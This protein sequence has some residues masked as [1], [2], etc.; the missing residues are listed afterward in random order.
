MSTPQTTIHICAG[1]RLNNNYDHTIAFESREAQLAYFRSKVVRTYEGYAYLR[2]RWSIKVAANMPDARTWSYLFFMNQS[3]SHPNQR[4]VYYFITDVEY[5]NDHT[6]ELFLELDVMQSYLMGYDYHLQ[7]CFVER[8]HAVT[9]TFGENTNDEGLDTGELV[10][11]DVHS[12]LDLNHMAILMM[13][14]IDL[15]QFNADKTERRILGKYVDGVFSGLGVYAVSMANHTTVQNLLYYLDE[16]GKTDAIVNMWMYPRNLIQIPDGQGDWSDGNVVKD[17]GNYAASIDYT[18]D[19]PAKLAGQYTPKNAKLLQYPYS[20]LYA[21]TNNGGASVYRFEWFS[22]DTNAAKFRVSGSLSA[23]AFVK[24]RPEGYHHTSV[25]FIE[26]EGLVMGGYPTC[27]WNSDTYK[28]WLAQNQNQ[29]NLALASAGLSIVAGAGMAVA[30]AI[31]TGAT[32]GAGALIGGGSIMGG[33]STA[34]SGVQQI[35]QLNAQMRD[36][37]VQPPAARGNQ[38]GS[39][40]I[41]ISG[42]CFTLIHKTVDECHARRIDDYFTMYGYKTCRV[43]TPNVN[44]RPHFN[45]VKTVASNVCGNICHAD[46]AKIN[47]VFDRGITF[48]KNGDEIG[49][50]SVDN[51]PV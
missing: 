50:Y 40:N 45:Y 10:A 22:N 26:D 3:P 13:S 2:K 38:S 36:Y 8:E 15:R 46:L 17:V 44:S 47:A 23:D 16:Q 18:Y 14:S 33:I 43:K 41:A 9:D 24:L 6:V 28:L 25:S 27:A 31:V 29:H 35:A 39:V 19:K 42:H 1:V 20:I 51:R 48:W 4:W 37:D 32:G 21:T 11:V 34:V 12:L 5:V 49:D 30:G 7:D